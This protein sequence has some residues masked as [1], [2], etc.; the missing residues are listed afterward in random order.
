ME[1]ITTVITAAILSQL[2][3]SE[4]I[5]SLIGGIIGN[6]GD[7]FLCNSTNKLYDRIR[8][9]AGEPLNHDVQ[10]AVRRAYLKATLMAVEYAR[11]GY[12]WQQSLSTNSPSHLR[13]IAAYLT[14]ELALLDK[15]K[16][17]FP[18][19][20]FNQAYR[21]LL[22]PTGTA[23]ADRVPEMIGHLKESVFRELEHHRYWPEKTLRDA[24]Q[25]GWKEKGKNMDWYELMC[26]FFTEELKTNPRLAAF[27]QTAYLQGLTE[28]RD[29][30]SI[31]IDEI[32]DRLLVFY[33][34]YQSVF[35]KLDEILLTAT[36]ME[37]K[38]DQVPEA[39]RQIVSEELDKRGL[40]TNL[41][42]FS[43]PG[44]HSQLLR[45]IE[46]LRAEEQEIR[47]E[48]ADLAMEVAEA[49]D[50]SKERKQRLLTRA[51]ASLLESAGQRQKA[52]DELQNFI[53]NVLKLAEQFATK[54]A[55]TNPLREKARALFNAG[56]FEEAD[57]VLNEK[58]IYDDI[59][60]HREKAKELSELLTI[61]AQ[62]TLINK[63]EGWFELA[64]KYYQDAATLHESYDT[65]FAYAYFLAGHRKILEATAWY[66]KALPYVQDVSQ[67]AIILNN[68][69][70]LQRD[71]NEFDKAEASYQE[72][73]SIRR[74]LAQANPQ[75]YL[76]AVAM[77]LNNLG[78][79]QRARNEFDRAE[80]SYQEALGIYQALAQANPQTYLPD[81]A[82]T[83]NNL[84]ALQRDKNDFDKAEASYQEALSIKRTLAQ[85]NPQTY[86]PDVAMT[87]NNLGILQQTKKEFDKAEGSYQEAL[88]IRRTLAQANP[89]VFLI[90]YATTAVSLAILY[91]YN[92]VNKE[93]SVFFAQEAV[94]GFSP[95]ADS[96]P[97]AAQWKK[98]AQEI[99]A[100]WEAH[101]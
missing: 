12:T 78:I 36:R 92:I 71:K 100:Y 82:A 58:V 8:N 10:K 86:L 74:T 21:A 46:R 49:G 76:P 93:K 1:P 28:D 33:Q 101:E 68:L 51:E 95:F 6:R 31:R 62:T 61:K 23:S 11:S 69:G 54:T 66:E 3:T 38:L 91:R 96:I 57:A 75:T 77:T 89:Q 41:P 50:N 90:G 88:S 84:G 44:R 94:Q 52:E 17:R 4:L 80:A 9:K 14:G 13:N 99:L 98:A 85:A 63:P 25:E 59:D 79:L 18:D 35:P 24:I 70:I 47:A 53:A 83:L 67:Q 5:G 64:G 7:A 73:L 60:K 48:I 26:A 56:R 39:M 43:V 37:Q 32:Q 45:D 20:D 19:T 2:Q 15:G 55:D 27:I 29:H 87:L 34:N 65:C 42:D 16:V 81:V 97:F 30:I 40:I 72:A 22:F